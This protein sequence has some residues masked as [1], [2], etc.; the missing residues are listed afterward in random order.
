MLDGKG[1]IVKGPKHLT[2]HPVDKLPKQRK[3]DAPGQQKL[4]LKPQRKKP[5]PKPKKGEAAEPDSS[6]VDLSFDFDADDTAP[7]KTSIN[8]KTR[9]GRAVLDAARE[10]EVAPDDLADAA[11]FIH[12][13]MASHLREREAAKA[14]ARQLTGLTQRDLDRLANAGHDYAST[15]VEG[16][17]GAKLRKFDVWA[18][19][20]ARQHPELGW[21]D[22]ER[23]DVD[24][25]R[26]LWD[27]IAE[28]KQDVPPIYDSSVLTEAA[29]LVRNTRQYADQPAEMI[30]FAHRGQVLRYQARCRERIEP[31]LAERFNRAFAA[32]KLA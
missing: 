5:A 24:F 16:A 3:P 12:E 32:R 20:I 2:G 29:E 27:L 8:P 17:T 11:K 1:N 13:E 15:R 30:P 7:A 26:L 10:H 22:P 14:S 21:G 6:D 25:S 9:F 31:T 19:E 4:D 28:G 18:A 23:G